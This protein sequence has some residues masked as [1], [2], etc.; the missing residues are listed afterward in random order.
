MS[1]M[2]YMYGFGFGGSPGRNVTVHVAYGGATGSGANVSCTNGKKTFYGVTDANG[3][4]TFKLAKGKWT[5]TADK[6]GST[7]SVNVDITGDCT[8]DISLFAATINITYPKGYTCTAKNGTT[9]L[10]A[11]DTSGTWKC[12]VPNAGTWTLTAK[13][14]SYSVSKS[15][16]ITK[17]NQNTSVTIVAELVIFRNGAFQNGFSNNKIDSSHAAFSLEGGNLVVKCGGVSW[18]IN[19]SLCVKPNVNITPYNTLKF[20]AATGCGGYYMGVGDSSTDTNYTANFS[21]NTGYGKKTFNIDVSSVNK[22]QYIKFNGYEGPYSGA[23][24]TIYE[25]V[26][27]R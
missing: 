9:T 21:S 7:S 15:A 19:Y 12:V 6:S 23:V 4:F 24:I 16:S 3:N 26:L 13:D 20:V 2:V 11:P 8:V 14:G 1:E 22:N 10:T 25:I 17:N 27:L 18:A 5:I